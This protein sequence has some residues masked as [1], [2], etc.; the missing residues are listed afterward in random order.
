M[1]IETGTGIEGY[2]APQASIVVTPSGSPEPA[3]SL[4]WLTLS[5]SSVLAGADGH[6]DADSYFTRARRGALVT[7]SASVEGQVIVPASVT[8][9][10]GSLSASFTTTPA[11]QTVVPRWVLVQAHYGNW[12]GSRARILE[13]D[14]AP[15][16]ATLLAIGPAGQD[17]IGGT[18][19][20]VS[21]GLVMPAPAGGG[22]VSLTTDNPSVIQVPP[23]VTIVDR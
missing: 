12:G 14:P 4:S 2:R 22:V 3:A 16:P 8:I 13:I 5:Q 18:P 7:L 9:P 1:T 19:A 15:G 21:V 6:R 17:V 20:R 23:S 11:P 10:A